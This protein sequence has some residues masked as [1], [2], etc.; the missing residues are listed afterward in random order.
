MTYT[1]TT[2][3][4]IT[5]LFRTAELMQGLGSDEALDVYQNAIELLDAHTAEIREQ[6]ALAL[7]KL[8]SNLEL[9]SS[10]P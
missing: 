9:R 8:G 2:V 10:N 7:E 4:T 5:R 6:V 3:K 1:E